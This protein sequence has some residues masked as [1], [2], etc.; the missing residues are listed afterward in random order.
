MAQTPEEHRASA[1]ELLGRSRQYGYTSPARSALVAEAQ[2]QATLALSAAPRLIVPEG[3]LDLKDFEPSTARLFSIPEPEQAIPA[4]HAE[5]AEELRAAHMAPAE[6]KPAP[7]RRTRKPKAEPE[8]KFD[9]VVPGS[10][11]D[12]IRKEASA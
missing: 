12:L 1:L 10:E 3:D 7:K 9:E 4:A 5:K 6:E 2:V 11:E 8:A